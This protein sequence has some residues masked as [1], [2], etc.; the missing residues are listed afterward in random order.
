[1]LHFQHVLS[2]VAFAFAVPGKSSD[3]PPHPPGTDYI[4]LSNA[5]VIRERAPLRDPFD[6]ELGPRWTDVYQNR[7]SG[8][9]CWLVSAMKALAYI[10]PLYIETLF[11][12][13]D[14]GTGIYH[15]T[16]PQAAVPSL[17]Y[18]P[19]KAYQVTWEEVIGAS[20][21][22]SYPSPGPGGAW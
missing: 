19:C 21:R 15:V 14:W 4:A 3:S 12:Q 13:P 16:L 22:D 20:V 17:A 6:W 2:W 11:E 1:M 7:E 10:D 5:T 8:A 9:N 18:A